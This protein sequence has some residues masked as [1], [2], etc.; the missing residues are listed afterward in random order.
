[1]L[2]MTSMKRAHIRLEIR[3]TGSE[4][5]ADKQTHIFAPMVRLGGT[6]TGLGLAIAREL[7]RAMQAEIG[8]ISHEGLGSTFWL[9]LPLHSPTADPARERLTVQGV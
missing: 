6:G 9:E 7:A 5:P 2:R 1:M 3:D 4:I 8:V